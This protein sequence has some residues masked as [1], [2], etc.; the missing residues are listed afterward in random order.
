[1]EKSTAGREMSQ[2]SCPGE[3]GDEPEVSLVGA[4]LWRRATE[5]EEGR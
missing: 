3:V 1:M 2:C 5:D 4:V